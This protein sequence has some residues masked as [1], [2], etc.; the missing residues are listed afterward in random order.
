MV[1]DDTGEPGDG[2]DRPDV[3][4]EPGWNGPWI[5]FPEPEESDVTLWIANDDGVL[6]EVGNLWRWELPEWDC[7]MPPEGGDRPEPGDDGDG[8]V[9]RFGF[10]GAIR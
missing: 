5:D 9:I 1:G 6:T 4:D 2:N 7:P 10:P 8:N 3:P